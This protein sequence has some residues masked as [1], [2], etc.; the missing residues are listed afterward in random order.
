MTDDRVRDCN[1][2]LVLEYHISEDFKMVS[3]GRSRHV[4]AP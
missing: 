2:D 1:A 4:V 3:T